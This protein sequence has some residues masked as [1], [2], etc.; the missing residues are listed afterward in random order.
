[1]RHRTTR[2]RPRT[3]HREWFCLPS[4]WKPTTAGPA[5][6]PAF[7]ETARL[8]EARQ[9]RSTKELAMRSD[10]MLAENRTAGQLVPLETTYGLVSLS[11][12]F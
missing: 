12:S 3:T 9:E 7:E 1:M 10:G 5:S 11:A 4:D 6:P 8:P 2:I